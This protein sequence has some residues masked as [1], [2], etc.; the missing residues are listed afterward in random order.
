MRSCRGGHKEGEVEHDVEG[1][2]DRPHDEDDLRIVE[3]LLYA[4]QLIGRT[5]MALRVCRI[6]QTAKLRQKS[7]AAR[8]GYARRRTVSML[9]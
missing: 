2:G 1:D 9:G 6:T 7:A 3:P 4:I 5:S 8:L